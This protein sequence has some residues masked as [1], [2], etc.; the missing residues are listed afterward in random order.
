MRFSDRISDRNTPC[1]P[2]LFEAGEQPA[3]FFVLGRVEAETT[4]DQALLTPRLIKNACSLGADALIDLR[5]DTYD[6][7]RSRLDGQTRETVVEPGAPIHAAT[8]LAVMIVDDTVVQTATAGSGAPCPVCAGKEAD[9]P[10]AH[11][12][13]PEPVELKSRKVEMK[14]STSAKTTKA[15]ADLPPPPPPPL[16]D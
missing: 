7:L 6:T 11:Q 4:A 12:V 5:I 15:T 3:K 13:V 14:G 1:D 2:R 8:A 16:L 10:A 9:K